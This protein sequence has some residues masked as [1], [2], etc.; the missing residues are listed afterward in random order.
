[1]VEE[2]GATPPP[3]K[4]V[5]RECRLQVHRLDDWAR[6]DVERLDVLSDVVSRRAEPTRIT[7]SHR[8]TLPK[9]AS[10]MKEMPGCPV[11]R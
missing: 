2:I 10:G 9:A 4:A 7:V 1:M 6:F 3:T 5:S 11:P 8:V